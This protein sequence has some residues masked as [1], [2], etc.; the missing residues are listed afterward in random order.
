MAREYVRLSGFGLFYVFAILDIIITYHDNTNFGVGL[1]CMLKTTD[2]ALGT[3]IMTSNDLLIMRCLSSVGCTSAGL[4]IDNS[5]RLLINNITQTLHGL[6][7]RYQQVPP[8]KY[9]A[10]AVHGISEYVSGQLW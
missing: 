5:T 8:S 1:R 6:T 4:S 2:G 7:D 3:I 9:L 10:E